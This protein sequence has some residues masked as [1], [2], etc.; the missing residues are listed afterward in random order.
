MDKSHSLDKQKTEENSSFAGDTLKLATGTVLAQLLTLLSAPI[1][2]RVYS[3]EAFGILAVFI[4][5]STIISVILCF[6]YEQ[7]IVLPKND[8]DAANLLALSLFIAFVISIS[9]IPIIWYGGPSIALWLN[10]PILTRYL[11]L[12]VPTLF[13]G[14][15]S[16]GHP[17]LN[18]WAT[19]TRQFKEQSLSRVAGTI[20]AVAF[21]LIAGLTGYATMGFLVSGNVLGTII[22]PLVLVRQIWKKNKA[23]FL[24]NINWR[25]MRTEAYRYRKFPLFSTWASLMNTISWQLPPL[26]LTAFFSA[27]ISGYYAVGFRLLQV[28]ALLIGGATAQVFFQ[29]A[30][31]AK[32]DGDLSTVVENTFNR[33][34]TI[35]LFPFLILTFAGKDIFVLIFGANYAEAGV[36]TQILSVWTFFWFISS[37]M[38]TLFIVLERQEFDLKINLVILITRFL[39]LWLGGTQGNAR[40][41]LFYFAFSGILV[42]GYLSFAIAVAAG[43]SLSRLAKILSKNILVFS[44]AGLLLLLAQ[45]FHWSIGVKF[46]LLALSGIGYLFYLYHNLP[47]IKE[48]IKQTH[49]HNAHRLH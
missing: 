15:L 35:G 37:P 49:P 16:M 24:N 26:M 33:L 36:Y 45:L 21:Q 6:R 30:A 18:Y 8:A 32:I 7:A 14:G 10:T 13:F 17:A 23:L 42:Y 9:A 43:A 39:S 20:G 28:P 22:A 19:R 5:I 46:S 44:P 40:L 12:L 1:L 38:S 27:S 34:V 11:W 47:E 3:P 48:M 31:K 2:T 4:S 25:A 29:R 41:A